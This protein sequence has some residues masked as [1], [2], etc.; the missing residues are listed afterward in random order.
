M[1]GHLL[2]SEK[3]RQRKSLFD[4]VLAGRMT[5][6]EAAERLGISYRHCRRSFK[7][8][9][10]QGDAGL[11]HVSRGKPSNRQYPDAL[12]R[13]V[14]ERYESRYADA[15]LGPTLAAEK[16]AA[17][18]LA[19][20]RETL[21]RWLL[22]AGLW[23]KRR[24]RKQHRMRRERKHHFGELVQMDGSPHRWFGPE[25]P[26]ACLMNMV[27]DATA[28]TLSLMDAEETTEISMRVLWAWIERYGIPQALYTDKKSVFATTREPTL[29]EQL[30][31]DDPKTAFGKVCAKLG[32]K[33]ILA[34]SPQA[35]GRVERNHGIYQDRFVKEL[36]LRR[37]TTIGTANRLLCDGF[38]DSLNE[39]FAKPPLFDMDFHRPV[40]KGL[41]LEDVFC[42]EHTRQ[43]QND[44]TIRYDNQHYQIE[45]DN[46]QLPRPKDK[47][48]VRTRLDGSRQLL[49]NDKPLQY[50][51]LSRTELSKRL[52]GLDKPNANAPRSSATA[53]TSATHERH[54]WRRRVIPLAADSGSK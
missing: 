54:P 14:L 11:V 52:E 32:I 28:T 38:I 50:H 5:R 33:I 25:R 20:K 23:K 24:K 36:A 48:V 47:V 43:V 6:K 30:A 53:G 34:N 18:G 4:E 37:I 35:K 39:K 19:V 10:E 15:G 16:L 42:I 40:P 21:R 27:D 8:F 26:A 3:E 2:M 22:A 45:K 31:G 51:K 17:D 7:R 49:F 12:R 9:C 1:E 13:K 29:E 41:K 44:W 46:R